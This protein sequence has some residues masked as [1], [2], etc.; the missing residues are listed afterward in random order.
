MIP[1]SRDL[2]PLD[3]KNGVGQVVETKLLKFVLRFDAV[4][5]DMEDGRRQ[6]FVR[7][8]DREARAGDFPLMTQ[9]LQ[10]TPRKS[11]LSGAERTRQGHDIPRSQR[12]CE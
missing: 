3:E 9:R 4:Q 6:M 8:H 12:F 11:G 7:L 10:Q 2:G 1:P 5:V